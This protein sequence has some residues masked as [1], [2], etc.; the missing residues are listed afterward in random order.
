MQPN[1]PSALCHH[2]TLLGYQLINRL[3]FY[4]HQHTK[5]EILQGNYFEHEYQLLKR[6]R[7]KYRVSLLSKFVLF[8]SDRRYLVDS[9]SLNSVSILIKLYQ[10]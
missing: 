10:V 8:V 5:K 3:N 1:S 4:R 7:L 2:V 9:S 6:G